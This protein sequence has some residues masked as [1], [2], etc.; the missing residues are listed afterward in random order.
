MFHGLTRDRRSRINESMY[1]KITTYVQQYVLSIH[2]SIANR[3]RNVFL[4]VATALL[5]K[6]N[7]MIWGKMFQPA[8]VASITNVVMLF[9]PDRLVATSSQSPGISAT[10]LLLGDPVS[11]CVDSIPK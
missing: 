11:F 6:I 10:W 9:N 5:H 2:P 8:R 1:H 4:E 3:N 7:A